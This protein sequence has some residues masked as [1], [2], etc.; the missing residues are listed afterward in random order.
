MTLAA[1]S[2]GGQ[3]QHAQIPE[4][5]SSF[6]QTGRTTRF[7]RRAATPRRPSD[8]LKAIQASR[9]REVWE[10]SPLAIAAAV[11]RG[12]GRA[13]NQLA[14]LAAVDASPELALLRADAWRG[15]RAVAHALHLTMDWTTSTARPT[16]AYLMKETG[17]PRRTLARHL[18]RLRHAGLL[19]IVAGGRTSDMVP[20]ALNEGRNFAAVYVLAVPH[21]LRPVKPPQ[22]GA[23]A[24]QEPPPAP[25]RPSG[26]TAPAKA[27]S[28][29]AGD[30]AVRRNGTPSWPQFGARNHQTPAR[31]R[32]TKSTGPSQP[33][34]PVPAWSGTPGALWTREGRLAAA[35]DLQ[36]RDPIFTRISTQYVAALL[37]E[38]LLAGWTPA[39]VQ[40]AVNW[41]PD[42]TA[43]PHNLVEHDVR[44]VPG[45]FRHRLRAW[46]ADPG[47]PAS[48]PAASPSQRAAA[49]REAAA[50][51]RRVRH[52]Q[53]AAAR[54]AAVPRAAIP[55]VD[56][57]VERLRWLRR[58]RAHRPPLGTAPARPAAVMRKR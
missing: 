37:R 14:W 11:P 27:V 8:P 31:A 17:L 25:P 41:R 30:K 19:G 13:P 35:V 40:Q 39:D 52:E 47:N 32:A 42:G 22:E 4:L 43:W 55:V 38:W 44:H 48:P 28:A 24:P 3:Y 57:A 49:R 12:S 29:A 2:R 6:P 56:D 58:T 54:A 26:L 46:R 9:P 18:A 33:H 7:P 5:D 15:V 20:M 45:W 16:W 34:P 53:E 51:A 23:Q 21:Q 1:S 50:A 36:L 10:R